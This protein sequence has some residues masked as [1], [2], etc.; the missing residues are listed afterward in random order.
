MRGEQLS[1][2]PELARRQQDTDVPV[3][4]GNSFQGAITRLAH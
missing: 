1:G 4:G 2:Q 3:R